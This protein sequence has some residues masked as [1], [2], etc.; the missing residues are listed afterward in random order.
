MGSKIAPMGWMREIAVSDLFS[1]PVPGP[2]RTRLL[3]LP[4]VGRD[5]EDPRG[6]CLPLWE[7][8]SLNHK[9]LFS[10]PSGFSLLWKRSSTS[11]SCAQCSLPSRTPKYPCTKSSGQ[12]ERPPCPCCPKPCFPTTLPCQPTSALAYSPLCCQ[13][14]VS[15]SLPP[16]APAKPHSCRKSYP[17]SDK[18][19]D[20]LAPLVQHPSPRTSSPF[21]CKAASQLGSPQPVLAHGV[22]PSQVQGSALPF[23]ELQKVSVSP[24]LLPVLLT[25]PQT[26]MWL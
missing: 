20:S 7:I 22:V 16:R 2:S 6:P 15:P 18:T 9:R 10:L 1:P 5:G 12:P 17:G 4:K 19:S 11:S 24:F 26:F 21:F 23:A 3:A 14:T 8:K 13:S 25:L